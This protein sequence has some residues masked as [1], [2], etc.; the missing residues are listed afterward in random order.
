[1]AP[2]VMMMV[3]WG[4]AWVAGAAG[5]QPAASTIGSLRLALSALFIFTAISHFH[6]RTRPDLIR[7][8]PPAF[9]AAPVL[10]TVT[11]VLE[12]LGAIGLLLPALATAAAYC[13]MALLMALFP[14]NVRA[15]RSGIGVANGRPMPLAWRAI[16]Q[17][18]WII[19][20][21]HVA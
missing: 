10:V 4:A 13:L 9:P 11:G 17:L 15:A 8:V 7:M 20:L 16:L 18:F 2:L 14:A 19:S 6:R 3:V 21:W 1:M 5:W 12:F